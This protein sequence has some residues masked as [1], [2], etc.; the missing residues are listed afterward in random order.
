MSNIDVTR[1]VIWLVAIAVGA[2]TLIVSGGLFL[3]VTIAQ[4]LIGT[5]SVLAG[6]LVS[7]LAFIQPADPASIVG[8]ATNAELKKRTVRLSF[9]FYLYLLDIIALLAF[10]IVRDD[11][12]NTI[13]WLGRI[14]LALSMFS[15]VLSLE[16]PRMVLKLRAFQS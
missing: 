9:F 11:T 8:T 10:S 12:T 16:V 14:A 4:T 15:V 7:A 2:V 3:D 1:S 5:F 6:F 13:P